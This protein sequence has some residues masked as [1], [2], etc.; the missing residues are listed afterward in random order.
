MELKAHGYWLVVVT[1][2]P[3][4]ARGTSSRELVEAIHEH[5]KI[6]LGLDAV[7][8]CFHDDAD[9]CDCRKPG[10]GM[11]L[12]AAQELGIDLKSSFMV[13]DR[14]RDIEA[15]RRA[16]CRTIWIDGG[17][18]EQQAVNY[19]FRVES[20]AEAAAIIRAQTEP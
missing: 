12:R 13:G 11:L 16:G 4:V 3:D 6:E 8:S 10:P 15:G 2:Q 1:N 7:F 9:R 14:W 20:L 17:Y 19:H 5:L 18:L